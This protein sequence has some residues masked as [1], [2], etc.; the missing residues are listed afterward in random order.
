MVFALK[1]KL[2]CFFQVGNQCVEGF[3]LRNDRQVDAFGNIVFFTF[4]YVHLDDM[5]HAYVIPLGKQ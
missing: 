1:M 2:Q 4:V 5:F 3:A